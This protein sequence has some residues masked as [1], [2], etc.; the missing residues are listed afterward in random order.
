[1][2]AAARVPLFVDDLVMVGVNYKTSGKELVEKAQ[3]PDP[4]AAYSAISRIPA[5]REVVLLQTCNRV[6]VYAITTNKKATVESIKSLLEARA[7]E[8]IPEEKFVI[9]YGTDAVRHLFRVAAGLESM[10][11]GEPDILRQVR[12]AAE[13]AAKEGYI[14]KALK[15]TFEN[16]VRVGKRVRT[17]TALGKGS[18]GIPSASV[19]LL[20]ELIG[21]EGKKLL[22]V[23]AGMA[24]RVVAVNAAKRGAKVIIVNR[25]LSKA[26][27]LA[28]EV[29]G[30]AYPLEE[31]PR[32]L[33]E[34][35]AV[36]V[37]VGGG[38]KVITRDA[39]AEV[40]KKLV[41]VDIS[42]PPA[43]D[44]G[45]SLNPYVIYK[46]MLAVAEV[47]NRGL[48]KRKSE[49]KR[50]EDIIEAELNKFVN[51]AQ[52]VLADKILRELM[53]KVEQIRI[54]E[55][56]KA[57]AKVPQEYAEVLDKMTSSL[58][59]KV[60]K[61]VILKVREAAGKGDLTTL[62]IVA[63]VFDLKESLNNIEIIYDYN[64]VE[65]ELKRKLEL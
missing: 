65:Q 33:R 32:L 16:A 51:F 24:G 46:D 5:V 18:I 34:A 19:K 21:L 45:V 40:N 57:M 38:S 25:T 2:P 8:P 15:L 36:V 49:I 62:R 52:R 23:G 12:E 20:E 44:P 29:G 11:L 48:E 63:E 50:A 39:V 26:K 56:S 58:V 3:F 31:L 54:N 17:E 37:A 41:I 1:M 27:E 10:V 43:V 4:L 22:V 47:A 42:E 55:L 7:G 28:E 61:D 53:E 35:D 9:Y 30:E 6:E 60:L 13:F 64:G 14:G 59:K